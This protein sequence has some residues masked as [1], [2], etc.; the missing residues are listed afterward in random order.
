MKT[1]AWL[2]VAICLTIAATICE[3]QALAAGITVG[4]MVGSPPSY[5]DT[6]RQLIRQMEVKGDAAMGGCALALL[7]ASTCLTICLRRISGDRPSLPILI[8]LSA[9]VC[10]RMSGFFLFLFMWLAPR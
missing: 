7:C 8:A 6:G 2:C 5:T 10:P 4:D 1:W 3:I 9:I